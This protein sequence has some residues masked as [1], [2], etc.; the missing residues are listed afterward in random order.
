MIK[1]LKPKP[2]AWSKCGRMFTPSPYRFNQRT[3]D[4]VMCALGFNRE[5]AERKEDKEKITDAKEWSKV[6]QVWKVDTHSKEY[7]NTLQTEINKLARIIDAKFY[8]T[9]IDCGREFGKQVDA[10]HFFSRGANSSLRY[11]LHNLHSAASNCNQFSD[12]HKEGY[13]KGLESRHGS[14]YK[15]FVLSLP[16]KYPEIKISNTE[17]VE[18]L[19]VVRMLIRTHHTFKFDTA[20]EYR[21][22]FNKIIGIY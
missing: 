13:L 16:Q 19:K 14:E 3:C 4:N 18:K 5:K 8:T 6:R 21:E 7:R 9:C 10:A 22:M 17:V 15:D 12:T 1:I 20:V 2:C 11:N